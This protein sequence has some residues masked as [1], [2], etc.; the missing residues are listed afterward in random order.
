MR[1]VRTMNRSVLL[2]MTHSFGGTW[3]VGTLSRA[4]Q[5]AF[6]TLCTVVGQSVY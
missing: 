2:S 1:L 3:M 6:G 5:T 4:L